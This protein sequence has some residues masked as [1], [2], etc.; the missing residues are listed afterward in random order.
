MNVEIN[1]GFIAKAKPLRIEKEVVGHFGTR[2]ASK[3]A[4]SELVP[5]FENWAKIQLD[6]FW[7]QNFYG[8][9]QSEAGNS[10][11]LVAAAHATAGWTGIAEI[12]ADRKASGKGSKTSRGLCDVYLATYE[13]GYSIENKIAWIA[14]TA[15]TE[16]MFSKNS[17]AKIEMAKAQ[18]VSLRNEA[19]GTDD[20]EYSFGYGV[21]MVVEVPSSKLENWKQAIE[22][23][24]R[25]AEERFEIVTYAV[26]KQTIDAND[27]AYGKMRLGVV[28]GYSSLPKSDE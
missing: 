9:D 17:C 2:F 5:V 15:N 19:N 6:F 10:S 4:G 7:S 18:A 26:P 14:A 22:S 1:G 25:L 20:S 16:L 27:L 23:T 21:F 28:Y 3:I 12:Y 24:I 8:F 11:L 13:R